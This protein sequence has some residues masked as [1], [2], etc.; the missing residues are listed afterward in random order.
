MKNLALRAALLCF[1]LSGLSACIQRPPSSQSKRDGVD[2]ASMKGV[3][4]KEVP[5]SAARQVRAVYA[6]SAELAAIDYQPRSPRP[7]DRVTVTF[8]YRVL[9]ETDEDWKIF[10]HV[11]N[12]GGATNRINGDH[13]P[14]GDKY[15]TSSWR[16][17]EIVKDVWT[18]KV[19]SH[20]QG[21]GLDLWTGFYQVGKDDRWPLTNK[22]DVRHDGQNR[23]LAATIAMAK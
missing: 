23:V 9:E 13:W 18:F 3:L 15:R 19:P 6:N 22:S 2:R 16:K 20:F 14:A 10:V 4:L 21:E 11:D 8:Y 7:G 17:G 5:G 1:L 12:R